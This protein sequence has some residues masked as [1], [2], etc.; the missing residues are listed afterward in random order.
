MKM[1]WAALAC[2]APV[3]TTTALGAG[4]TTA[5]SAGAV[6]S[7][8]VLHYGWKMEGF[9][10][11]LAGLFFPNHGEGSLTTQQ[12]QGGRVRSELLITSKKQQGEFWLYGSELDPRRG[13]TLRAWSDYKFR[14]KT[15]SREADLSDQVVSDVASG[16]YTLRRQLPTEVQR[17]QIWS[18]GKIYAV[19][20]VPHDIETRAFGDRKVAG[21]LYSLSGVEEPGKR[22]WNGRLDLW[23]ADDQRATP[24]EIV[25]SRK[26]ARVRMTL[27]EPP[28]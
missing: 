1:T 24:M 2:L 4:R 13:R 6:R 14:G 12:R 7:E 28:V 22:F 3:M 27:M 20:V 10:G 5:E 8:E 9:L 26:W 18:D 23:L 25:I 11:A 15:K 21:R 19:Q 16:I 17:I